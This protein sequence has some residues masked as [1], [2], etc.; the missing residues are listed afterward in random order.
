MKMSDKDL[1]ELVYSVLRR[2]PEGNDYDA[3]RKIVSAIINVEVL[4]LEELKVTT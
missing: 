3:T 1:E 4:T 2:C